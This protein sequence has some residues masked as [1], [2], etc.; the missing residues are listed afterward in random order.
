[1]LNWSSPGCWRAIPTDR[2]LAAIVAKRQSAEM[3]GP[4]KSL[5]SGNST[6]E[7]HDA[8]RTA[9]Q[10]LVADGENAGWSRVEVALAL[11]DLAEMHVIE[12][13]SEGESMEDATVAALDNQRK[14]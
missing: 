3:I 5:R 2:R 10:L 8:M 6:I 13:V 4:P 11:R 7:C 12:M 1:M 14:R 9:F